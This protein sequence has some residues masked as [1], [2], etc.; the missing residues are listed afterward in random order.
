[1]KYRSL[2]FDWSG[3]LVDDLPPTLHATNTVLAGYDVPAMSREEFRLRFRLPYPEFYEEVLPGVAIGDLEDTFRSS[4]N[5]SPQGVTVLPHAREMLSWCREQGIRCFVLSSMDVGLFTEQAHDFGLYDHF[6]AIYAGVID[7]RERI[8]DILKTH[9]LEFATTAFVGD[10]IHDVATAQHGGI[11]SI[12]VATGYDSVEK[13]VK[14]GP[15]QLF[16]HL[17][18]FR[19]WLTNPKPGAPI[20]T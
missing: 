9:G 12:A 7:K 19:E 5:E 11:D 2:L 18:E 13:L 1:M 15:S 4:F 8:G 6:E 14:S 20:F 17:G 16:E 10:M 3:T